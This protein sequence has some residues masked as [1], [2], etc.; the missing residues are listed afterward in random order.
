MAEVQCAD[1]AGALAAVG[2]RTRS[3]SGQP[4]V[5]GRTRQIPAPFG[6]PYSRGILS[7]RND[8]FANIAIILAGLVTLLWRSGWPDLLVGLGIAIVNADAAKE[9]WLAARDEHRSAQT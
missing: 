9:V 2:H 7:A 8:A 3:F 5:C 1:T 4:R 6:Q